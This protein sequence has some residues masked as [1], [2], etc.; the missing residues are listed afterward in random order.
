MKKKMILSSTA[1]W[2]FWIELPLI[3]LLVWA[4][5]VNVHAD[6]S[7]KL[8]PLIAVIIGAM[9]FAALFLLRLV[10]LSPSEI[11]TIGLFSSRDSAVINEGKRL[12]LKLIPRGKLSLILYGKNEM[13]GFDWLKPDEGD[14]GELPLFRAKVYGGERAASAVIKF[15]G[16]RKEDIAAILSGEIK[17]V[18][19]GDITIRS[20]VKDDGV[21]VDIIFNKTVDYIKEC[22]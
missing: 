11:K 15:F 12:S 6:G 1:W 3:A 14:G 20:S 10:E 16:A 9:I 22:H 19:S 7:L 4:L 5:S 18:S 2:A 21:E 17:E 8:Y 13:P